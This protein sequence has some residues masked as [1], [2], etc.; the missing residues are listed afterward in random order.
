M[1]ERPVS[2]PTPPTRR[3]RGGVWWWITALLVVVLLLWLYWA[4][5]WGARQ[6]AAP[7]APETA[8][9]V[10]P[11]DRQTGSLVAPPPI[12]LPPVLGS[13]AARRTA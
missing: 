12:A 7:P 1:T 6:P 5:G 9:E 4:W 3:R 2:Q 13:P 10:A 8:P 11:V